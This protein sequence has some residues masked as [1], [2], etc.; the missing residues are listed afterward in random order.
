[1]I[2]LS[3]RHRS[4]LGSIA[5]AQLQRCA[6]LP[7]L[8]CLALGRRHP[9]HSTK[10]RTPSCL[11]FFAASCRPRDPPSARSAPFPLEPFS[12]SVLRLRGLAERLPSF[13]RLNG[14]G[15]ELHGQS[16]VSS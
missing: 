9:C 14:H 7:C 11:W 3:L 4:I 1:M 6:V 2:H 13:L 15:N 8:L 5:T 12:S 10:Q 16:C